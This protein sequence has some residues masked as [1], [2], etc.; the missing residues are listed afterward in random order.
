MLILNGR[1]Q[2]SAGRVNGISPPV[3]SPAFLNMIVFPQ[4]AFSVS[5]PVAHTQ[6]SIHVLG[7]NVADN[8]DPRTHH[9]RELA[10]TMS[11]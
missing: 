11:P 7:R 2:L 8:K 3:P 9:I 10:S 4:R 5:R 1:D 6:L